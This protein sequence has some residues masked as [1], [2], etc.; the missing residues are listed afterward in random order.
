MAVGAF[1][2]TRW[3]CG[4]PP[5]RTHVVA[6]SAGRAAKSLC[7][8]NVDPAGIANISGRKPKQFNRSSELR[9]GGA[10]KL[11]RRLAEVQALRKLVQ[12]AEAGR[13]YRSAYAACL[14]RKSSIRLPD[15]S[16]AA[17]QRGCLAASRPGLRRPLRIPIF[18]NDRGIGPALRRRTRLGSV[19]CRL[20]FNSALELPQAVF[21]H[22][23]FRGQCRSKP[24]GNFLMER[25]QFVGGHRLEVIP[26]HDGPQS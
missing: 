19:R 7:C 23:L 12:K 14:I 9:G 15:F 3:T 4:T 13:P 22:A 21:K 25:P 16:C 17:S 26:V 6:G 10:A 18:R 5:K 24:G 1:V 8:P 11:A 2:R 20:S